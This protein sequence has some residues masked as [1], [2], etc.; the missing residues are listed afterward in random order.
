MEGQLSLFPEEQKPVKSSAVKQKREKR[1]KSV[2]PSQTYEER[3]KR[4]WHYLETKG[5]NEQ[6]IE[7]CEG[8]LRI[9]I[10]ALADYYDLAGRQVETMESVSSRAFW[11]YRLERIKQIQTKLEMLTGYS[12]DGQL[13]VC[14]KRKSKKDDDI[15]EDAL[16][17]VT[18]K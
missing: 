1:Q 11:A 14:M 13:E 12:R 15:G 18:R 6:W 8:E 16:V 4:L 7:T 3:H 5:M 17:L 9:I 2:D 10:E